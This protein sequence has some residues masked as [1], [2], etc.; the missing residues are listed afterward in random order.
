MLVPA[1][2]PPP[3][4]PE[5]TETFLWEVTSWRRVGFFELV[6][7]HFGGCRIRTKD[8]PNSLTTTHQALKWSGTEYP[9]GI[10]QRESAGPGLPRRPKKRR[11]PFP[12]DP[13]HRRAIGSG[14]HAGHKGRHERQRPTDW[15]PQRGEVRIRVPTLFRFVNLLTP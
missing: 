13:S 10:F 2:K 3:I 9:F 5:L 12:V 6:N 4:V 7:R 11:R 14:N 8:A 1:T 15:T